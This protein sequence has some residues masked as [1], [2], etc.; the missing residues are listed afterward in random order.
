MGNH[1]TRSERHTAAHITLAS[2]VI[3]MQIAPSTPQSAPSRNTISCQAGSAIREE[4]AMEPLASPKTDSYS[5][6]LQSLVSSANVSNKN[7][8]GQQAL[9][10]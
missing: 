7:V 10:N 9:P 8:V 6:S 4:G 5:G 3:Q 1:R 2:N